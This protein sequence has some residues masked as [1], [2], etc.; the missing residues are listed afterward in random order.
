MGRPIGYLTIG[1]GEPLKEM[2]G[3]DDEEG[4]I[5][6]IGIGIVGIGEMVV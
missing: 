5:G 3:V 2:E 4:G 1:L 6:G